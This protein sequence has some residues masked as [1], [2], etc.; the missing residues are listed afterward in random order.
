MAA[1]FELQ[2]TDNT[3]DLQRLIDKLQPSQL[4]GALKGVGEGG[5]G[6]VREAFQDSK[7][8]Y[9]EKWKDLQESTLEAFVGIRASASA[10]SRRQRKSYGTRPL[11]RMGALLSS[12]NWQLVLDGTAVVIGVSQHYGKYHQG[13]PD[14]ASK[15]IIPERSFLPKADRG[16]PDAWRDMAI[17][18]IEAFLEGGS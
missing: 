6:L 14:V 15:G 12:A 16:L 3:P 18:N 1:T 9:G 11:V 4:A 10:R 13:D 7:N 17:D 2:A 8:P 5:V